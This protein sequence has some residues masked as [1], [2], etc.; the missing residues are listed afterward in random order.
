MSDGAM[1]GFTYLKEQEV[2]AWTHHDTDGAI[3][4][5][6]G[7]AGFGQDD[8]YFVVKRTIENIERYYVERLVHR[9]APDDSRGN[10]G[11]YGVGVTL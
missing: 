5:T 8:I 4:S 9:I 11:L 6:C 10:A 1:L 3:Q 7:T 2:W